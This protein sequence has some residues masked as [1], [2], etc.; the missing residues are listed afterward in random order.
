MERLTGDTIDISDRTEFDF[1]DLS[2]YWDN[3]TDKTEGKTSI[4]LGV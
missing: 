1:Y 3:N 2:W 4:W